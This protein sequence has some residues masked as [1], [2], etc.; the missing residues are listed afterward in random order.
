MKHYMK[1]HSESC[2]FTPSHTLQQFEP[3]VRARQSS[4]DQLHQTIHIW[5]APA[6][7]WHWEVAQEHGV[8]P[9]LEAPDQWRH[10]CI[11]LD[12]GFTTRLRVFAWSP[13]SQRGSHLQNFGQSWYRQWVSWCCWW[14]R[15]LTGSIWW[16]HNGMEMNVYRYFSERYRF[17]RLY[18]DVLSRR[19]WKPLLLVGSTMHAVLTHRGTPERQPCFRI[20]KCCQTGHPA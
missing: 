16:A 8:G 19:L 5:W 6:R 1:L 7:C 2:A 12:R 14:A 4:C 15:H 17:G 20:I 10:R 11:E 3:A 9:V 13:D 18:Q